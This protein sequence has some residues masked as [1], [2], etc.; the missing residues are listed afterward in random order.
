MICEIAYFLSYR[1]NKGASNGK[2]KT[3]QNKIFKKNNLSSNILL[4]PLIIF[5]NFK[6]LLKSLKFYQIF[7]ECL[8][9]IFDL[10]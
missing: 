2:K 6:C 1:D 5:Q 4:I 3:K 7:Q 9:T 8:C 10:C